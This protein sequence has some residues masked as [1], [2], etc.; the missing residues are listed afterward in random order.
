MTEEL[1]N[2]FFYANTCHICKVRGNETL[3]K[4][5]SRCKMISYCG[6][7][8]Q[9]QHWLRHKDLCYVLSSML[10]ETN[11]SHIFEGMRNSNTTDW[12]K[13]KMN[14]MLLVI[15]KLGRKLLPY[16]EEMFKFPRAC[17]VCH[18]T[19]Q[20][21]IIDCIL[22]P[23]ASFCKEHKNDSSHSKICKTLTLCYDLDVA[24]AAL[25]RQPPLNTVPYY[26]EMISLPVCMKS[27]IDTY[28]NKNNSLLISNRMQ[29]P[30][31]SEYLT[32]PLTLLYAIEKL[33]FSVNSVITIHIIGANMI[34]LDGAE[35][36][37]ILL[38]WL[39]SLTTLN[40]VL[41]GPEQFKKKYNKLEYNICDYCNG[42]GIKFYLET[43]GELY[44]EYVNSN[45]FVKPDI[46]VGYNVGIHEHEPGDFKL[47]T[48]FE[49]IKILPEQNCPI[50]LT[51]YTEKEAKKDHKR[52]CDVLEKNVSFICC[53]ANPFSSLRPHRDYE[54]EEL[55]YQN[56]YIIIYRD[57]N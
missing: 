16:E 17:V 51:S 44:N 45:Y 11:K 52:F 25:V 13:A 19:D 15:I 37:E 39:P 30:Q 18:E 33:G 47:D 27:F 6:K 35:I 36:W 40:I 55:Y 42:K 31:I 3:L 28:Y 26:T 53:E 2:L 10:N 21:V 34:E 20:K 49:S 56:H 43:Y 32:R 29:I 12:V 23:A 4:K 8:H 22:C 14:L 57:F 1:D 54:T 5:C 50:M 41:I 46:I 7:E 38:H 9:K 24:S 48:W